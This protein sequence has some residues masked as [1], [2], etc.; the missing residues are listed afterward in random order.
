MQP[1]DRN[2]FPTL[3]P[4]VYLNHAGV[5]PPSLP[6]QRAAA[7]MV[8]AYA[9]GGG[10]AVGGAVRVRSR[11]RDLVARLLRADARDVALTSGTSAGVQAIA[12]ALPWRAGDR[13]LL[14]DGEFPANVLPW[15]R[16][17]ERFGLEPRWLPLAPFSEGDG[18]EGLAGVETE[19][20]R[21]V[22]LVAVSAVQFRSG[23]AMPLAELAS[24]CHAHGAELFVDAV[25]A[26]GVVPIDAP[27]LG[28]DYLAGGAHKWLMG[29]EGCGFLWIRPGRLDALLPVT[30][31][32]LSH[33]AAADFLVDGPGLLRY[34]RPLRTRADR[35]EGGSSSAVSQAALHASL[36]MLL[37]LGIGPIRD[38]VAAYLD[39][40]EPLL[41]CRGF[42][43]L[44]AP[45]ARRRSGILSVEPPPGRTAREIRE[46]LAARGVA[47]A[48]PDGA[49][50][51]APHWPNAL[52]EVER[53]VEA[54]DRG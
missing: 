45:D 33:E 3:A 50:R 43:S 18:A 5:S 49:L 27:A 28:I 38:H 53:V 48:T 32:W 22:R 21:G 2:L 54:L 14:F 37:Q 13:V 40:L 44:R 47:V 20:R 8:E 11:L 25:Q 17:A 10:E 31:G 1:G 16:A 9:C 51:F 30:T 41:V 34:D 42:R 12:L 24:L 52:D 29:L 19:L 23:L 6:V 36:D 46:R 35:L 7:A 15:L 4:G 26:C 39:R